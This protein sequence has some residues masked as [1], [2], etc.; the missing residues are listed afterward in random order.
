M[1]VPIDLRPQMRAMS[2]SQVKRMELRHVSGRFSERSYW[3]KATKLGNRSVRCASL[4]ELVLAEPLRIFGKPF[5][6]WHVDVVIVRLFAGANGPARLFA[7]ASGPA[8]LIAGANGPD[9]PVRQMP[10]L[11]SPNLLITRRVVL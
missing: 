6:F 1:R 8:R 5:N 3:R 9:G 4:S 7:G 2:K 10:V 11:P